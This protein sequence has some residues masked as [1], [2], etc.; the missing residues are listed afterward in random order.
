MESPKQPKYFLES[1]SLPLHMSMLEEMP[2][3]E[4][5]D[6]Y[7]DSEACRS[8]QYTCGYFFKHISRPFALS[9]KEGGD[10]RG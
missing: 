4:Y 6:R 9:T 10:D 3:A 8:T 7:S 1:V 2:A 5:A